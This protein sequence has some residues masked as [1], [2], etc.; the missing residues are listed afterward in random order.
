F[1]LFLTGVFFLGAP[2]EAFW[3]CRSRSFFIAFQWL[4]ISIA[5]SAISLASTFL[6]ALYFFTTSSTIFEKVFSLIFCAFSSFSI[7]SA[8]AL[9]AQLLTFIRFCFAFFDPYK[10]YAPA[11]AAI[12]APT[13]IA[14]STF[15]LVFFTILFAT[16]SRYFMF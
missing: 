2:G 13:P 4:F 15:L 16:Y 12:A 9:S 11:A 6:S 7:T 8:F 14:P 3:T 10:K 5:R 1:A